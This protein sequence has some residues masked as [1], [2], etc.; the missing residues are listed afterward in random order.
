MT[1]RGD[2]A[3]LWRNTKMKIAKPKTTKTNKI[4]FDPNTEEFVFPGAS[5]LTPVHVTPAELQEALEE[6]GSDWHIEPMKGA[7]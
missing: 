2:H 6:A 3:S 1:K 5:A 4:W 7:A